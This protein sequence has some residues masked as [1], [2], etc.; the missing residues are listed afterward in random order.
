MKKVLVINGANLNFLGIREKN[1]YG[2]KTLQEIN[3]RLKKYV[4]V[5]KIHIEFFQS[6]YEGAIVERIHEAYGNMDYIIINPGAFT[7]YSIA[8]RDALL[9]VEI[10][11]IEVHLSN[12]YRREEFRHKSLISDI[13]IGTICG[14]GEEGY[15]MALD[16]IKK[17]E[18]EEITK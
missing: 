2:S 7:H 11:S 8:I 9:A 6:N 16:Y 1:I 12:I 10:P 17:R 15:I 5:G 13:A 4:E 3:D 18:S 14:F